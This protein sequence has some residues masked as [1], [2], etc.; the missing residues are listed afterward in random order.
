MSY[1]I[2]PADRPGISGPVC[3]ASLA[4]GP[5]FVIVTMVQ[6]GMDMTVDAI[7]RAGS[8]LLIL[9]TISP[10]IVGFGFIIAVLPNLIGAWLLRWLSTDNIGARLPVLWALVGGLAGGAIGTVFSAPQEIVVPLAA[11]GI[12]CALV[13]RRG[14][15]WP[16]RYDA[17]QPF[18][19]NQGD[20]A[21]SPSSIALP[22][23]TSASCPSGRTTTTGLYDPPSGRS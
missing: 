8:W 11:S 7:V 17:R 14:M 12:V 18:F 13:C 19:A 22:G 6:S 3:C 5:V 21:R 23:T 4:A 9:L 1:R 10:F 20:T 15:R 16:R 2:D